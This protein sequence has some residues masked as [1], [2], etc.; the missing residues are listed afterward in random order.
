ML[1]QQNSFEQAYEFARVHQLDFTLIY[2]RQ[3]QWI[4]Q[5]W[6]EQFGD[7]DWMTF[8]AVDCGELFQLL[9]AAHS[10]L[11]L[12]VLSSEFLPSLATTCEIIRF[13]EQH[14]KDENQKRMQVISLKWSLFTKLLYNKPNINAQSWQV[15][16]G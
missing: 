15:A 14:V 3:V 6:K 2:R 7:E 13:G 10:D 12:Y 1:I 11:T 4:L 16:V 9:R 8:P 5:Q